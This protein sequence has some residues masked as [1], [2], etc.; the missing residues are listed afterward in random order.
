VRF[1]LCLVAVAALVAAPTAGADPVRHFDTFF[2]E[3]GGQQFEIV[4]KPGSSNFVAST[5]VSILMGLTVIDNATGVVLD[6]F[7]KPYT[8]HQDVL[9]CQDLSADAG[10]TVYVEVLNTP[11]T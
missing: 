10:V 9:V 2:I 1:I 8:E 3:C 11:R 6:E 7:H 4:G 5:S